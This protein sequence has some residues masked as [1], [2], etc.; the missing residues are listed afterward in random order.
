MKKVLA[1]ILATVTF[2][3]CANVITTQEYA[4]HF[5]DYDAC[6]MLY[7]VNE[8]KVVSEY[9]PNNRCSQRIAANSTFKI[10]LSL[11]AF[12]QKII[13]QQTVFKWD[14][15]KGFL[16]EHDKNQTPDSWMKYS[17]VWV[18]QI[19]S[20]QLGYNNMKKYLA[21]FHYGNQDISGDAGLNNGLTH[22]WLSS[23]LKILGQEQLN[24]LKGMLGNQLGIKQEAIND[25]KQNMYL[26]KR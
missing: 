9:N 5:K 11:M 21:N 4:K 3:A 8:Q 7:N 18:S 10:A 26:G 19:I 16:S 25:T 14:G 20:P 23:S 6:F 1:L 15:K 22:S 17:V 24:L 2:G 12:D 13:N